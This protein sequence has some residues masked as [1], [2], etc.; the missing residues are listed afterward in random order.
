MQSRGKIID[1]DYLHLITYL[2]QSVPYDFYPFIRHCLYK[3]LLKV[4][5]NSQL[6]NNIDICS[7]W[8]KVL[9]YGNLLK[10]NLIVGFLYLKVLLCGF[11]VEYRKPPENWS[12]LGGDLNL[13]EPLEDDGKTFFFTKRFE[14]NRFIDIGCGNLDNNNYECES[15]R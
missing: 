5:K 9:C 12:E 15:C 11:Q 10:S 8:L 4:W 2:H 13:E 3:K 7:K 6:R 14:E 1:F